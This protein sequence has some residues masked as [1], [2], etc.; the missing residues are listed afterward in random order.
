MPKSCHTIETAG[1]KLI[2][3]IRCQ[4]TQGLF[5]LS[6]NG[7]PNSKYMSPFP[8]GLNRSCAGR[9]GVCSL[10]YRRNSRYKDF[11]LKVP[12]VILVST[13]A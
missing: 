13:E 8:L 7:D 11:F 3:R 2:H 4:E 9:R 10:C 12:D 5:P 6:S 1:V